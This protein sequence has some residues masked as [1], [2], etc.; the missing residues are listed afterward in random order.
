MYHSGF[1]EPFYLYSNASNQAISGVLMEMHEGELQPVAYAARKMIKI[2]LHYVT[3]Q[4]EILAIVCAFKSGGVTWV[5]P[6][7]S[8]TQTMNR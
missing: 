4:Q 1:R 3:A 5:V 6:K 2:E 8:C 7:S